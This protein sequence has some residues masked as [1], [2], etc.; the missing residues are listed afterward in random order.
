MNRGVYAV[1][2]ES[3]G[4]QMACMRELFTIF[5]GLNE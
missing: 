2:D 5:G 3:I 4:E 1:F